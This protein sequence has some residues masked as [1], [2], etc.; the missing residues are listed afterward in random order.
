MKFTKLAAGT[1]EFNAAKAAFDSLQ[2]DRFD[3][4][5]LAVAYN[6][7]AINELLQFEYKK[8]K[9]A[10]ISTQL[11][12]R[13]LGKGIDFTVRSSSIEGNDENGVVFVQRNTAKAAGPAVLGQR[14]RRPNVAP[15][16]PSTDAAAT[17]AKTAGKSK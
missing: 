6:D 13:G 17:P 8:G 9:G 15:T 11:A 2:S 5:G 10:V 7:L 12:K 3:Y 1:A 4:D 16:A 14:G